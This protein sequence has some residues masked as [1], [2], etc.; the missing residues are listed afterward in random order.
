MRKPP[1][2]VSSARGYSAFATGDAKLPL[3]AMANCAKEWRFGGGGQLAQIVRSFK[4][5][6]DFNILIQIGGTTETE[7]RD[8]RLEMS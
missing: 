6:E 1:V 3:T 8:G 7:C 4:V 5:V 2:A